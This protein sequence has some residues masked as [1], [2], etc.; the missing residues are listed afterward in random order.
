MLG[1]VSMKPKE[2]SLKLEIL[3]VVKL[4]ALQFFR[5]KRTLLVLHTSKAEYFNLKV[6]SKGKATQY[7]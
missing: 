6:H 3:R 4:K 7:Q 2:D 5:M 1:L